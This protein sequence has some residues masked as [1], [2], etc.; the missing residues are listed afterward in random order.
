MNIININ[1]FKHLKQLDQPKIKVEKRVTFAKFFRFVVPKDK[2]YWIYQ[3]P[4]EEYVKLAK[5]T[6]KKKGNIAICSCQNPMMIII[7]LI[8]N[9]YIYITVILL[10]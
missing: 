8:N 1:I 10:L 6:Q 2:D 5:E 3:E 9:S 4:S 7:L